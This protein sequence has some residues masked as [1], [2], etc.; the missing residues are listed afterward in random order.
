[1]KILLVEDSPTIRY[2]MC[3]YIHSAGHETIIAESGEHAL[4]TLE[5]TPVDM[6]IMDVEMPGLN[7]FETTRLIREWLG[8]HWVPIIFVTGKGEAKSL[9]EGIE[10]GGDDYLTKPVNQTILNAKVR[11]M[12]RITEMRNQLAKLN[13]ELLA[14]SQRDSL[15]GL[16]NR[17]AFEERAKDLWAQ[18]MRNKQPLTFLLLDIDHFKLYNDCYGHPAGD[19]CIKEVAKVLTECMN[20]SADVVAR[21]GGEEFIAVLPDT[22]EDGAALICERIRE[23]VENLG[24]KHRESSVSTVVTVSV[25]ATVV[26]YTT[27]TFMEQQVVRA[28]KALYESKQ[29]GRNR[30]TVKVSS[31]LRRLLAFDQNEDDLYTLSELLQ[32]HCDVTTS[33]SLEE[34]MRLIIANGPDLI[35]LDVS[36]D[37]G[38]REFC[39]AMNEKAEFRRIP[40]LLTS[41]KRENHVEQYGIRFNDKDVLHKPYLGNRVFAHIDQ[42]LGITGFNKR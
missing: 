38:Q 18:A 16:F 31:P 28:D 19:K 9:E 22:P 41:N 6:I 34:A 15:T 39:E 14:L 2:A 12:E 29:A 1:M 30:V 5:N 40:I 36:E 8:D 32:G 17:R 11:A 23:G 33:S 7:G 20:R 25:G 24:I 3:N 4:Q 26:N 37:F 27:G 13:K 10:A 35:M 21:Y 42:Y